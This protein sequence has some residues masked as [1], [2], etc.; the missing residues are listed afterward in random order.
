MRALAPHLTWWESVD[1]AALGEEIARRVPGARVLV[2]VNVG[3]ETQKGGC[4]PHDV[5]PL[6]DRLRELGL[7][8]GGLMTVPPRAGEPRQWFAAL[9]ALAESSGLRELS[10]GMSDDF[11]IAVE[12]GATMVRVGRALFGE[13]TDPGPDP[14]HRPPTIG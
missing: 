4:D 13:R 5:A 14:D 8:V 1:R 11:E 2:E 3:R 10:M 7:A 9:R 6:V 12:E